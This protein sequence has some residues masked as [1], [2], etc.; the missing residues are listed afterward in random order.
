MKSPFKCLLLAPL[1][2]L[3]LTGQPWQQSSEDSYTRYELLDPSSQSFRIFY[4]VTAV[5]PGARYYFNGLRAGSDHEIHGVRDLSTGLPL[6]WKVVTGEE[7]SKLGIQGLRADGHYLQISLARPVPKGGEFRLRIDKTY[8][9]PESY[10]QDGDRLTFS[11]SLGIKRNAVVLPAGYELISCNY[12]SQIATE[13][14]GRIRLS[15]LNRGPV[16]V[17][18]RIEARRLKQVLGALPEGAAAGAAELEPVISQVQRNTAARLDF[19]FTE[20]AFQDREIVYFLNPPET[21]SFRLYHDYTERAEGIDRYLNVV[22]AGSKASN[23]SAIDL[24]SG[25]SLKVETLKGE[26]IREKG[27]ELRNL[28][29]DTE[30]VVIWFDPVKAGQS[31]RLRIEETYTDASRYLLAGEELIWDRAFGRPVNDVLLPPGWLL[32]SSAVPA[33][34]TEDKGR[35]RLRFTNDRPGN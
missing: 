16:A 32:T 31:R 35:I 9:D 29:A 5:S 22:R 30:V 12:P 23:P 24:D 3:S 34:V 25:R 33:T 7:A 10:F 8:R 11:R 26:A 20:R 13:A 4:D 17:P 14:D 1:F 6:E 21:H 2:I 18:Y 28:T 15:F 27:I 19:R